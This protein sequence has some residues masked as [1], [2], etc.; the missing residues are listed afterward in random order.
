MQACGNRQ[1][2]G[3]NHTNRLRGRALAFGFQYRFRHFLDEQRYA[4]RALDDVLPDARSDELVTND[5][6]NHSVDV[7]AAQSIEGERGDVRL[8]NPRGF[9]LW[10][11]R[12]D[13]QHAKG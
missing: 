13:Q 11:K 1:R 9:E 4:V 3:W 10:P 7:T 5:A 2:W 8:S 6:I 12:H